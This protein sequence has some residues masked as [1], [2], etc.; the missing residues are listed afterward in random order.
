MP[1]GSTILLLWIR[2]NFFIIH[3]YEIFIVIIFYARRLYKQ[4]LQLYV[5]ANT[6]HEMYLCA[7]IYVTVYRLN[8]I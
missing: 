7:V 1:F 6:T 4:K 2:Y 8:Q 3:Y 5:P